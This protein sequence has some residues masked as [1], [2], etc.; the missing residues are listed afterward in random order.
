MF[1]EESYLT[2]SELQHF[3][4][5]RRRWALIFVETQWAENLR[6]IEGHIFHERVHDHSFTEKRGD[7]LVSRGLPVFSR[8]LGINGICDVVE[9]NRSN[10]GVP[11]AGREGLWLP[12]P[13]EYKRGKPHYKDADNYQLCGQAM[14]LEEMFVCQ[15]PVAYVYYGEHRRRVEVHLSK[16]LREKVKS[17]IRE[18]H[19]YS[20]R[21]HTPRVKPTKSCKSCSLSDICLPELDRVMS[22]SQ[23][24][25]HNIF[26][27]D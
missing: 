3:A 1:N 10:D 4:F 12:V 19:N 14:C 26:E 20:K 21:D 11:I 13:V 22:V 9:F 27:D 6:T 25:K 17:M 16:E 2:L 23:Y 7:I 8:S 15:I 24:V 18:M 5:C